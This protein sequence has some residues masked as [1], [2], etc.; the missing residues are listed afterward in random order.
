MK[1]AVAEWCCFPCQH[2]HHGFPRAAHGPG[3]HVFHPHTHSGKVDRLQLIAVDT[4]DHTVLKITYNKDDETVN[5]VAVSAAI[6]Q[7]N[8]AAITSHTTRW[9][10]CNNLALLD[11]FT[12]TYCRTCW[13][14]ICDWFLHHCYGW[15]NPFPSSKNLSLLF[16]MTITLHLIVSFF[17]L[18]LSLLVLPPVFGPAICTPCTATLS[19]STP[20]LMVDPQQ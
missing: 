6:M 14:S 4:C 16:A 1:G 5:V 2:P 20:P 18:R 10:P 11:E 7:T 12:L 17:F 3:K 19:A 8:K 13:R 15:G 9:T